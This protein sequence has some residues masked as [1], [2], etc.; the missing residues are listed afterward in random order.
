M[1]DPG[2]ER[3]GREGKGGWGPMPQ[4]NTRCTPYG[5]ALEGGV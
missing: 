4:C 2:L 5:T 1:F 3:G